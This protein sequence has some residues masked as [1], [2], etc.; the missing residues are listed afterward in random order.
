MDHPQTRSRARTFWTLLKRSRNEPSFEK[1]LTGLLLSFFCPDPEPADAGVEE[2][3]PGAERIED[4][5]GDSNEIA[6][7]ATVTDD[8]AD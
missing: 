6:D 2:A 7:L 3:E 5:E 4:R 1:M 8:E